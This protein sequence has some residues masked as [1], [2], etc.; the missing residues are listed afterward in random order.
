MG[1]FGEDELDYFGAELITNFGKLKTDR[2]GLQTCTAV[3]SIAKA[4]WKKLPGIG[5]GHPIFT[6][7]GMESR[8]LS[9][10]GP[11]AIAEC[12]YA[13]IDADSTPPVYDLLDGTSEEPIATHKD[14]IEKIAGTP[15]K[16][17]NGAVFRHVKTG[18][19]VSASTGV[20]AA[21]DGYIF[22][23]FEVAVKNGKGGW[24]LSAFAKIEQ[25]LEPGMTWRK[26]WCR[27][28]ALEDISKVGKISTPHGPAPKLAAPQNWLCTSV[29]QQQ[30]GFCYTV[31]QDWRQSGL[32]GWNSII[33][34]RA[35]QNRG[36][37]LKNVGG[38]AEVG[39]L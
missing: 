4:K 32:R 6:Y 10:D 12:N 20:A 36:G 24:E 25:Y 28:L 13:G 35:Q 29:T 37:G 31:T 8:V 16:P 19:R 15:M 26:S 23:T 22:D 1:S 30:K 5:A 9:F 18:V 39:G 21:N 7:I 17:L 34:G 38:L 27:K 14:F 33:Y 3:F 2:T 11:Y